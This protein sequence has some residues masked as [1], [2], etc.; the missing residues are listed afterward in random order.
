MSHSV[1]VLVLKQGDLS[2]IAF[3][4]I[5]EKNLWVEAMLWVYTQSNKNKHIHTSTHA[6]NSIIIIWKIKHEYIWK[7]TL[8]YTTHTKTHMGAQE[9]V[10]EK[11]YPYIPNS[12][13]ELSKAI[14][15][16]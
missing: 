10:K 2:S 12:S 15:R 1:S 14:L 11:T 16:S 3:T 13:E 8:A 4:T 7:N 9:L 5:V 6:Q